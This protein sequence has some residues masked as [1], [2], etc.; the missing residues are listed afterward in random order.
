MSV[1]GVRN[2]CVREQ[3]SGP[4]AGNSAAVAYLERV[5]LIDGVRQKQTG[6]KIQ[7]ILAAP[8]PCFLELCLYDGIFRTE[9]RKS[10]RLNSS[11]VASSYAVFCL[12]KKSAL[13]EI[14]ESSGNGHKEV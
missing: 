4:G 1:S 2:C 7:I 13:T 5:K 6:E 14:E 12:K 3:H 10:T 11:H 9:D 8:C